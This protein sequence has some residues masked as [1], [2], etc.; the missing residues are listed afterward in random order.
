MMLQHPFF[1]TMLYLNAKKAL[2]NI[3]PNVM[4]SKV[5]C[6]LRKCFCDRT[7]PQLTRR[8]SNVVLKSGQC[9][10]EILCGFV[11]C[12]IWQAGRV[13]LE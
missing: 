5:S 4:S 1:S 6:N 7:N 11:I 9:I 12:K 10:K 3:L 8:L 13:A 2:S